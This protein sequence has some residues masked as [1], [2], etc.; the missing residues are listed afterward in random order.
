V[1]YGT[2]AQREVAAAALQVLAHADEV[3]VVVKRG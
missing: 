2:A 3:A 1:V